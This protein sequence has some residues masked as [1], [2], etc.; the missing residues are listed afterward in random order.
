M[1]DVKASRPDPVE[2]IIFLV[3]GLLVV[4]AILNRIFAFLKV[5]KDARVFEP[6]VTGGFFVSVLVPILKLLSFGVSALAL[7]GIIWSII[8]LTRI[9]TIQNALY[10]SPGDSDTVVIDDKKNRRWERVLEHMNSDNQNDWKFAIL[11]AD[12]IL[13]DLLDVMGYRGE[14]VSDKLKRVEPSDF[15]T[16]E[17]AWEAHKVRNVIAHEGTDFV[18]TQR[19]AKRIID[20]YR[21]VFEE[22]HFI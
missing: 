17:A 7:M 11:E 20:L 14:T 10:V 15:E 16:I 12:I 6:G 3:F 21:V 22:F 2:T 19:E 1:A 8:A 13:D 9:N 4:S 5:V 18:V